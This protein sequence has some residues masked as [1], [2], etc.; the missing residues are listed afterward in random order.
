M[1]VVLDQFPIFL[2]VYGGGR[3]TVHEAAQPHVVSEGLLEPGPSDGDLRSL[4]H[5]Q[6]GRDVLCRAHTVLGH[7][8]VLAPVSP[9]DATHP[10]NTETGRASS[11]TTKRTYWSVSPVA[12]VL[13]LNMTLPSVRL[14][15]T[16]G[17]G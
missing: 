4:P 14:H 1:V 3:I 13:V 17:A 11:T 2:P 7:T 6:L 15:S 9:V 12:L 5:Y 8:L 16:M 10:A